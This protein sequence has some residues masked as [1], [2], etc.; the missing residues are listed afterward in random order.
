[1][2]AAILCNSPL[3]MDWKIATR[4]QDGKIISRERLS[5]EGVDLSLLSLPS[6]GSRSFVPLELGERRVL[7]RAIGPF[8]AARSLFGE[9]V[10]KIR[11][12]PGIYL[13]LLRLL[14]LRARPVLR[15]YTFLDHGKGGGLRGSWGKQ[16]ALRRL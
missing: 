12:V 10:G 2:Q 11:V 15:V 3:S 14:T 7:P 9:H 6:H 4:F 16:H 13:C 1:M 5:V 8:L